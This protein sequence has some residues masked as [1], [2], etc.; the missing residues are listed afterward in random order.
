M[1]STNSRAAASILVIVTNAETFKTITSFLSCCYFLARRCSENRCLSNCSY[2]KPRQKRLFGPGHTCCTNTN[3]QSIKIRFVFDLILMMVM[4]SVFL[5][6]FIRDFGSIFGVY[7]VIWRL[8]NL[9]DWGLVSFWK[10]D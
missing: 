1:Q 8:K 10:W 2:S 3:S 7:K 4:F 9:W 5:I 6:F